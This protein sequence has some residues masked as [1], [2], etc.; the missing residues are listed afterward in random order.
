MR[1]FKGAM[2]DLDGTLLLTE[3]QYTVFW[4]DINR[5]YRPE[6]EDIANRI[7]GTTLKQTFERFFPDPAM[8]AAV[9][10]E[11]DRME[12][13]MHYPLTEGALAF[14]D[15]I[16]RHGV[17]TAIITSSNRK[18]MAV[19]QRAVPELFRRMDIV[20]MSEDF[21]ASKPDPDCYLRGAEALG[22]QLEECVVFEDALTGLEAGMRS[23]C[24]TV[25]L[26][27]GLPAETVRQ[28]CHFQM[29]DFRG[30]TYGRVVELVKSEE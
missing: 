20:L 11:L 30:M 13:G 22:L 21:R 14:I 23:G 18:K 26:S 24:Y 10:E 6:V 5:R 15:D 28:R 27:T 3:E 25:G 17:R 1:E 29:P 8:Q 9:T 16:R 12:A 19:V 4:E 7:K 2:F